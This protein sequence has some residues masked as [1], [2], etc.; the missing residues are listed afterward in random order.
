VEEFKNLWEVLVPTHF[1]DGEKIELVH[2]KEW[3][4]QVK[5]ITGGLTILSPAKGI[6]LNNDGVE[7]QESMIPVQISCTRRQMSKIAELTAL[8]YKQKAIFIYMI[9]SEVHFFE[10]DAD[11]KRI[12]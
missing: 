7:Y 3:D 8:H 2:H 6:W 9:S 5:E 11:F 12:I 1:N 4:R 10:F